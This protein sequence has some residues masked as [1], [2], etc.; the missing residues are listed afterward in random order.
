M[1]YG[2]RKIC[3]TTY[4]PN[5]TGR[6]FF[7]IGDPLYCGGRRTPTPGTHAKIERMVPPK[8]GYQPPTEITQSKASA[9]LH[10]GKKKV[11]AAVLASWHKLHETPLPNST[12]AG[13]DRWYGFKVI[14]T[15]TKAEQDR[16][17]QMPKSISLPDLGMS[18]MSQVPLCGKGAYPN[19]YESTSSLLGRHLDE[20]KPKIQMDKYASFSMNITDPCRYDFVDFNHRTA[21][22]TKLHDPCAGKGTKVLDKY[23][24]FST[25]VTDPCRYDFVDFNHPSVRATKLYDP[26]AGPDGCSTR[27]PVQPYT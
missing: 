23:A 2:L 15:Q 10:K 17:I 6:D 19:E 3:G 16:R 25:P 1:A 26:C 22:A 9:K 14:D 11:S 18:G 4:V 8:M 12:G 5:G 13:T 21:R 20:F 27:K 24:S 7:F